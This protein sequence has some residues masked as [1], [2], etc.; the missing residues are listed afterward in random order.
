MRKRT[1][2]IAVGIFVI[3]A[4]IALILLAIK[5][6]G[7]SDIYE[8]N[9]GYYLTADFENVGGLKPRARVTIA[10]VQVGRVI[11]IDFDQSAFLA[12]VTLFM[13][14]NIDKLPDDS[15]ASILTSGL[16]GDNF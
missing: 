13:N 4:G 1:V 8:G 16:L 14:K 12:R 15:K 5:V 2:E 9:E 10:G 6:S 11:R 3:L 7:L